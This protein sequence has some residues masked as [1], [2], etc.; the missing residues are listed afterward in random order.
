MICFFSIFLILISISFVPFFCFAFFFGAKVSKVSFWLIL[1]ITW[2]FRFFF[3]EIH[4]G[5]NRMCISIIIHLHLSRTATAATVH[6]HRV[7]A[8]QM[9]WTTLKFHSFFQQSSYQPQQE[10]KEALT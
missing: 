2:I 8:N 1:L 5:Y 7:T 9:L 3:L 10:E 4:V 6:L